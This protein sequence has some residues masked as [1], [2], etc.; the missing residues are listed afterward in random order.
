MNHFLVSGDLILATSTHQAPFLSILSEH[1]SLHGLR[2]KILP[3]DSFP[4]GKHFQTNKQYMRYLLK[5]V[6]VPS[7]VIIDP[8]IFHMSWTLNKDAKLQHFQQMGDWHVNS[9]CLPT[10]TYDT[11]Q[12]AI[13][14][15]NELQQQCCSATPIIKC[16]HRDLPSIIPCHDSPAHQKDRPSWY[17]K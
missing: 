1:A 8:W 10:G 4:G 14:K 15:P 2:V 3:G 13:S 6:P 7:N 11:N 16:H 12:A 9:I 17:P 5:A